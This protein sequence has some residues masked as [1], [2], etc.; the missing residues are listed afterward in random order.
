[1]IELTIGSRFWYKDKL[2]ESVEAESDFR[3]GNCI[4]K[5]DASWCGTSGCFPSERHDGKPVYF[6]EVEE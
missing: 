1:M 2:C 3:C 4:L 6:K 5:T